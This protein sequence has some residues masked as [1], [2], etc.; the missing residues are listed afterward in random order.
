MEK[1]TKCL[2]TQQEL[3]NDVGSVVFK[4]PNCLDYDIV[5][6]KKCRELGT[7]YTCPK[8]EFEGPN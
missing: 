6:S 5:R 8:C 1:K 4:C 3:T 7:K 2:A